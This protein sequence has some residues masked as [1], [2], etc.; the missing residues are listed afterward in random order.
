MGRPA[1]VKLTVVAD[2]K[3]GLIGAVPWR[4]DEVLTTVITEHTTA[5][6]A[7]MAPHKDAERRFTLVARFAFAVVNPELPPTVGLV[8]SEWLENL[9]QPVIHDI[10][11]VMGDLVGGG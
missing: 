8:T 7:V 6:A 2:A 4:R 1:S 9:F 5:Y 10:S 11:L 3:P